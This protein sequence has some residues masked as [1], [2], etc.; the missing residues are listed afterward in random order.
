M[1]PQNKPHKPK[2]KQQANSYVP[3]SLG[4]IPTTKDKRYGGVLSFDE[5]DRRC[6]KP[7]IQSTSLSSFFVQPHS[8]FMQ[9]LCV[10]IPYTQDT[11]TSGSAGRSAENGTRIKTRRA[12]RGTPEHELCC[13][14]L[15]TKNV[16]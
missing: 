11:T 12:S 16:S 1:R 13:L 4:K 14:E 3:P 10:G 6:A 9:E 2:P 15:K 7:Q 8:L 5:S